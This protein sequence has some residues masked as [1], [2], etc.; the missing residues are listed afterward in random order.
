MTKKK[1]I[2]E[3]RKEFDAAG[4]FL[5]S[6]EYVSNKGLLNV[7]C[8]TCKKTYKT[9]YSYIQQ[10]SSCRYCTKT[11]KLSR[12]EVLNICNDA[13]IRILNDSY[14][15][16]STTCQVQ[17]V[18]CSHVW[19]GKLG[20][21]KYNKSKCRKCYDSNRPA[22]ADPKEI[23]KDLKAKEIKLLGKLKRV[24]DRYDFVCL[25]CSHSWNTKLNIIRNGHGCPE[26]AKKLKINTSIKKYGVPHPLQNLE[27]ARKNAQAQNKSFKLKH[28]RSADEL[29]CVGSYERKVVEWLNKNKIDFL[30]QPKVFKTDIRTDLGVCK[31]YQPDL[32]LTK[33]GK[34]IEIKGRKLKKN[35]Q[36]WAWFHTNYPNSELWDKEKLKRLSIL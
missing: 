29:V 10:G 30:W 36:K 22:R 13:G 31:T 8:R 14:K 3:V 26:C 16:L 11:A 18:F 34:W 9:R 6:R 2:E 27:V 25:K 1:S 5:L 4:F 21:I 12:K 23:K 15:N 19:N 35:M 20:A 7:K 28:W 17:C 33:E 24:H 32:Y